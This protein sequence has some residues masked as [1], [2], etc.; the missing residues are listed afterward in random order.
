[1]K[2]SGFGK[3]YPLLFYRRTMDRVWKYTLFLGLLLLSTWALPLIRER[4]LG[5]IGSKDLLLAAAMVTFA[6]TVFAFLARSMAYVQVKN[7]HLNLVTPFLRLRISFRRMRS[8]HPVLLQQLFPMDT[9]TWA[10]RSFLTPFYGKTVIVVELRGYPI[11]PALLHFF[12][13]AQMFSP[14]SEG[15]VI[16]TDDWMKFSTELDTVHGTWMQAQKNKDRP[17]NVFQRR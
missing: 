4:N 15:L 6:L 9:A 13:P 16:M 10:Q 3:R 5:W 2:T 12:L 14:R 7:D 8:A 11:S 1:M 17:S